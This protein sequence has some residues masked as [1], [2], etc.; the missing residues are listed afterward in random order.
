M[1]TERADNC[2]VLGNTH[3]YAVKILTKDIK[4]R[5]NKG[6]EDALI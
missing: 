3:V 4:L 5:M 2:K 6:V 1:R